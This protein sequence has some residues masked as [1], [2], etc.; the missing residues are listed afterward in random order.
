MH[1]SMLLT[2]KKYE[3]TFFFELLNHVFVLTRAMAKPP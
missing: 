2:K 1:K 3:T